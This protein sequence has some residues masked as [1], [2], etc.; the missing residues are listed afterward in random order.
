M[1]WDDTQDQIY[2]P[3][4]AD[5]QYRDG[6]ES[7]VTTVWYN[8]DVDYTYPTIYST[9]C[10][11]NT[12]F[13]PFDKQTCSLAFIS[14]AYDVSTLDIR[15][16]DRPHI[17]SFR[18]HSEWHLNDVASEK[19][20][21]T[22][23]LVGPGTFP[24]IIFSMYLTRS[25]KM[26]FWFLYVPNIVIH[27]LTIVQFLLPC[28]STEKVTLGTSIFIAMIVYLKL[29]AGL[30]PM[31]REVPLIVYYMSSTLTMVTVSLVLTTIISE[32]HYSGSYHNRAAVPL[33]AKNFFFNKLSKYVGLASNVITEV[34]VENV[35]VV[36]SQTS[37]D[38]V[39]EEDVLDHDYIDRIGSLYSHTRQAS[40][41]QR[42]ATLLPPEAWSHQRTSTQLHPEPSSHQSLSAQEY[43]QHPDA[44]QS[45]AIRQVSPEPLLT[46]SAS[47]QDQPYPPD[48]TSLPGV[49]GQ[50][51]MHPHGANHKVTS[52]LGSFLDPSRTSTLR[53]RE[54]APTLV[55]ERPPSDQR[56]QADEV[57]ARGEQVNSPRVS[58]AAALKEN[59]DLILLK[60]LR[61]MK[62]IAAKYSKE[63]SPTA[64]DTHIADIRDHDRVRR[65]EWQ[66]LAMVVGRIFFFIYLAVTIVIWIVV[67]TMPLLR[68]DGWSSRT[69]STA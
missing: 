26:L 45:R 9:Y 25:S 36:S 3:D 42:Q 67:F 16:E 21:M 27:F 5:E 41:N 46:M 33:W 52:R 40:L 30:L 17:D 51:L 49:T 13:F 63:A 60:I 48:R 23:K 34:Q 37:L 55:E 29:I 66:R 28:D 8:G 18:E 14:F 32:L 6:P 44:L 22:N 12:F 64:A 11:I 24:K 47:N 7:P 1:R 39:E 65:D 10:T 43:L 20:N 68:D 61:G 19:V 62:R 35:H 57:W 54:R 2:I 69:Q 31:S 4:C 56:S 59:R 50:A 38:L 53:H 15:C 58:A